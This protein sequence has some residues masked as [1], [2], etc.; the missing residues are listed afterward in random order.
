MTQTPA[1]DQ[2]R[3]V[4]VPDLDGELLRP[5][6]IAEDAL[7]TLWLRE[8]D[9]DPVD[10]PEPLAQGSALA[11][12][13]RLYTALWPTQ[14]RRAED[15]RLLAPSGRY[16]HVPLTVVDLPADDIEVLSATAR[17]FGQPRP[18]G[19]VIAVL[20][21]EVAGVEHIDP[22][23][24]VSLVASL[25]GLLDVAGTDDSELLIRRLRAADP[26]S[27]VVLSTIEGAAYRA[28]AGRL[29]DVWGFRSRLD[30]YRY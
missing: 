28:T 20:V 18:S 12:V 7:L 16:E 4:L 6:R 23:A 11:A 15:G 14:S 29:G 25:A 3:T 2:T 21:D 8:Q 13:R 5:L 1:P 19:D 27:D 26:G 22:L 10:L 24:A 17:A 9:D 30:R